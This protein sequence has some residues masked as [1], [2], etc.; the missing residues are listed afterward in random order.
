MIGQTEPSDTHSRTRETW[1]QWLLTELDEHLDIRMVLP[2]DVLFHEDEPPAGVYLLRAGEIDLRQARRGRT[3]LVETAFPG[4]ILGLS[5]LLTHRN[6]LS[7]AVA[8]TDSEL[9][10]IERERFRLLAEEH[11]AVWFG[12]LHALSEDVM[13][14]YDV[15]RRE[16][17]RRS[18]AP[19]RA[20]RAR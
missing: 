16:F 1:S 5:A 10:F 19:T 7:T 20:A 15:L 6:H 11:P 3:D 4:R 17:L 18:S 2:G 12:L 9:G 8:K 13:H 14:S